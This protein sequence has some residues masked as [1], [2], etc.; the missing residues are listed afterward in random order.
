MNDAPLDN[1]QTPVDNGQTP[2]VDPNLAARVMDLYTRIDETLNALKVPQ[3]ERKQVEQ[4]LM[5]AVAAELLVRLGNKMT[6]EQKEKLSALTGGGT[7][8]PNLP[9]IA[10][11]FRDSFSSEELLEDLAAATESVLTDFVREMGK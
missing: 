6:D 10:L 9:D 11:F 8:E 4:N 1:S 3:H 5:E 2:S 7:V